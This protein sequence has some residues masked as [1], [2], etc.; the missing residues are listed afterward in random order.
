MMKRLF[1]IAVALLTIATPALA[2]TLSFLE[3]RYVVILTGAGMMAAECNA[4]IVPRGAVRFA[5]SIGIDSIDGDRLNDAVDAA[6]GAH[7]NQSYDR[8][9]LIPDVTRIVNE[10]AAE[11]QQDLQR[12]RATA[13]AEWSKALRENGLI[14]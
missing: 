14:E 11:I 2:E 1:A 5:D 9:K 10:A 3:K 4:K 7:A 12:D 6:A 8:S 13:C